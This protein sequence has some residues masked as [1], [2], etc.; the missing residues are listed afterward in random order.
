M[1]EQHIYTNERKLGIDALHLMLPN[2]IN[3]VAYKWCCHSS[4][5]AFANDLCDVQEILLREGSNCLHLPHGSQ[6][7][8]HT[9]ELQNKPIGKE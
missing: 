6:F 3:S 5:W 4:K 1:A 9:D 8:V 2:K 7:L